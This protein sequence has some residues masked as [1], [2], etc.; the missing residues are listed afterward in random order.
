MRA[1][2]LIS[3]VLVMYVSCATAPVLSPASPPDQDTLMSEN[4]LIK[5]KVQMLEREHAVVTAENRQY[6]RDL[7][8][9]KAKIESLQQEIK[10]LEEKSRSESE[11]AAVRYRNLEQRSAIAEKEAAGR[12]QELTRI[13]TE[14]EKKYT[15]EVT[16]L[17]TE[18]K[19]RDENWAREK[20]TLKGDIA[21]R[22]F[23]LSGNISRLNET[24]S[25]LEAGRA[26]LEKKLASAQQNN[27]TLSETLRSERSGRAA[28]E[29]VTKIKMDALNSANAS[30]VSERDTFKNL[31]TNLASKLFETE[32][33]LSSRDAEISSMRRQ[34]E[35]LKIQAPVAAPAVP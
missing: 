5:K 1:A 30:L 10:G 12:I 35:N 3:M 16:R 14:L 17:V 4:I 31:N 26:D 6:K 15:A 29:Q 18:M 34:I 8:G 24:I 20:E 13:N 9:M 21:R 28:Y 25:I 19:T 11:L 27:A 2:V 32:Q 33:K 7:D 22:E 23:E